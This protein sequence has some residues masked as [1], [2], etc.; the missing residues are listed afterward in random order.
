MRD[1]Y[2]CVKCGRPAEEVH[3]IEHLSPKNIDDPSVTLNMSNLMSLCRA[4]HF[5][6]HRG[7]HGKGREANEGYEYT[8][9]EN[10]MLIRKKLSDAPILA[11]KK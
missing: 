8:F 1:K 7:E 2:L 11:E 4:C 5:E 10:G 3:H 6:E 9:D